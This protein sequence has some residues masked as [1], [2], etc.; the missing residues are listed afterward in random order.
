MGGPAWWI[1]ATASGP[2]S[3]VRKVEVPKTKMAGTGPQERLEVTQRSRTLIIPVVCGGA[4]CGEQT[5]SRCGAGRG[6]SV[7]MSR[8]RWGIGIWKRDADVGLEA[9]RDKPLRLCRTGRCLHSPFQTSLD[10]PACVQSGY[11]N[12]ACFSSS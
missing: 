2:P 11:L 3:K 10:S 5:D 12:C 9:V 4:P 8:G 1:G 6:S 7:V